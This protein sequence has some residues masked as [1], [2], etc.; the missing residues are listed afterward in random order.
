[1]SAT[2]VRIKTELLERSMPLLIALGDVSRQMSSGDWTTVI[3]TND[4][5]PAHMP[6]HSDLAFRSDT[7]H[8]SMIATVTA[9]LKPHWV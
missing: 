8:G 1:M 9:F 3:L 5:W 4:A 6:A 7:Q 2:S